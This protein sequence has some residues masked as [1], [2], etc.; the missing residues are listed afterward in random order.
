VIFSSIAAVSEINSLF[1][2]LALVL[3]YALN[4]ILKYSVYSRS[5]HEKRTAA[6]FG[7][8]AQ[9]PSVGKES[10]NGAKEL[11]TRLTQIQL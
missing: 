10:S 3:L 5:V 4:R 8:F 2:Q 1:M 9:G 11:L 6:F 7:L